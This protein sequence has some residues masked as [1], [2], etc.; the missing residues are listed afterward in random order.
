MAV[1]TTDPVI[2]RQ[3]KKAGAGIAQKNEEDIPLYRVMGDSKIPVS[4]STGALWQSRKEQ[5]LHGRKDIEANWD[6]ALRYYDNDQLGHRNGADGASGN[7]PTRRLGN[8]WTETEN[9][10][11][12][13][14]SIMVPMLYAKNPHITVTNENDINEMR[15]KAVERLINKLFN[16]KNAPGLNFKTKARRS[17]LT[18]LLT[19][20]AF[21]KEIGRAHV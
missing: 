8:S 1:E 14:C 6:E 5:G 2:E 17:V 7:K 12:A 20:S 16:M 11:F 3:L 4:K 21:I 18:A 9:V 19:N 13:N 10:V 15:G